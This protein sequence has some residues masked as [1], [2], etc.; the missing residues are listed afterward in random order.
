MY[1]DWSLAG[2]LDENGHA[3]HTPDVDGNHKYMSIKGTF[4][5]ANNVIP[6]YYWFN[7]IAEEL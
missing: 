2:E 5:W 4:V 3:F 1:W 7:G 6:E